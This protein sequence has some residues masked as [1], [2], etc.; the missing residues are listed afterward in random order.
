MPKAT[1]K[2]VLSYPAGLITGRHDII[3]S[4][5]AWQGSIKADRNLTFGFVSAIIAT[6]LRGMIHIY[7][8]AR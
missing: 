2:P 3:F 6:A 7:P 5:A 4:S 1:T 8:Y